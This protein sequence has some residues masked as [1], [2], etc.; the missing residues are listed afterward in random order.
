[1]DPG[2]HELDGDRREDETH[3]AHQ[4]VEERLREAAL[5]PPCAAQREPGAP[6]TLRREIGLSKNTVAGIVKRS[7]AL[8]EQ[9]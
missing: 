1:M 6:Q 4:H 5:D 3:H 9:V 8:G 2:E 7:R